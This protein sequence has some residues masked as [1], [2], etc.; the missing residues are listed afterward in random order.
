MSDIFKE[1]LELLFNN[2]KLPYYSAEK[3]IDIFLNFFLSDILK[4]YL[5][6]NVFYITSEFP[7]RI[8]NKN[9]H[10]NELDYLCKTKDEIIF[11]ELK[12]D[13][14]S[15][16]LDQLNFYKSNNNWN[17]IIIG[18]I[19]KIKTAKSD[20][21]VKY[22]TLF[23]RLYDNSLISNIGNDINYFDDKEYGKIIILN[24]NKKDKGQRSKIINEFC[25]NLTNI[26]LPIRLL[27]IY[28]DDT[29]FK[30]ILTDKNILSLSFSEIKKLNVITKY[31]EELDYFI[32][33]LILI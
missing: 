26:Y 15:F 22:F 9:K 11:I 2:K 8:N 3:R 19:E 12:T 31:K 14:K 7:I 33:K 16:D 24:S 30:K 25:N 18:L 20:D 32:E 4:S 21:K 6:K 28:P 27:Y 23:K 1:L 10:S 13:R 5:K 29:S 17:K